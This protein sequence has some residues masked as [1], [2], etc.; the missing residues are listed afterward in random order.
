MVIVKFNRLHKIV[1][2][3]QSNRLNILHVVQKSEVYS[4]IWHA[5]FAGCGISNHFRQ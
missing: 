2:I 4:E 5:F 3:R 1:F